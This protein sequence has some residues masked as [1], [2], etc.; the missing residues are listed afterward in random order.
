LNKSRLFSGKQALLWAE[1]LLSPA[2]FKNFRKEC[3]KK[4]MLGKRGKT[5]C[6]RNVKMYK[7]NTLKLYEFT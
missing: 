1:Y 4:C 2:W 3:H 5:E 7:N 6:E